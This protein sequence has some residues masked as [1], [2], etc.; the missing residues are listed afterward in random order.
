MDE[1][2]AVTTKRGVI[3]AQGTLAAKIRAQYEITD[4]VDDKSVLNG[5]SLWLQ[6]VYFKTVSESRLETTKI[7]PPICG[8]ASMRVQFRW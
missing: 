1:E 8:E 3:A 2:Y 6:T 4:F 7:A 5:F